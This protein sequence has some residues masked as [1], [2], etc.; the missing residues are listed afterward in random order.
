MNNE[1]LEEL[2]GKAAEI[3]ARRRAA[4][5]EMH[6]IHAKAGNR[7]LL[8]GEQERFDRLGVQVER[9]DREHE[10]TVAEWRTEMEA[11]LA[12][13]NGY[14][15]GPHG[16]EQ[17]RRGALSG[18]RGQALGAVEAI[19]TAPD[20]VKHTLTTLV[21]RDGEDRE[22]MARWA[23]ATS[24]PHYASAFRKMLRDP[25]AGHLEFDA[26]EIAAWQ[27]AQS[28]RRSLVVG[29]TTSGGFM[30][31]A[32]LDPA[33]L[34]TSAGSTNVLRQIAR[35]EVLAEGNTWKGV[36][37]A[38]VTASYDA[39]LAEVSDDSPTLAQPSVPVHTGRAFVG[40][41]IEMVQDAAD[42]DAQ[43]MRLFVDARDTL[44]GAKFM[45]GSGTGEPR[46]I[47]TALDANTNV[48]ITS[49]TAATIGLVDLQTVYRSV[50]S[51]FRPRATWLMNP[52]Y[53]LAI[54]GLGVAVSS[55]FSG[56]LTQPPALNLLGKPVVYSDDAPATQTTTA[57]D[58][59]IVLGDF[60]Q[61]LIADRIGTT[62]EFIPHLFGTGA[63]RPIGA[64]G[65][66]MYWRSGA[67]T[68]VD[69]AFRLLQDKTS[70]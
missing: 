18:I 48:E 19:R 56:D 37:S 27:D 8:D 13:G 30:V 47:F 24:S 55:T 10:E 54:Q 7:S 29:T 42:L 59:E 64:R 51:R 5:D 23:L 28:V 20:A 40:A 12:A 53:G 9:L 44:E 57:L 33:V 2:R 14:F 26:R 36:S 3:N 60:S 16:Q 34:L 68:L 15:E 50:P 58:N 25:Q 22:L 45:L 6:E 49:T 1:R 62:I 66:L 41:S 52:L 39:E 70:A 32:H 43:V 38:G 69:E 63:G 4:R 65:W 11:W 17:Q 67:G 46:G 61:F 35:V 31:P 21:E